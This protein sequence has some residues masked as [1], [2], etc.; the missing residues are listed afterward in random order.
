MN[1]VI[2]IA[3]AGVNHNGSIDLAKKLID[4]A[5]SAGADFVKFQTFKASRVVTKLGEKADYQVKN[6][7]SSDSQ[8]NMLKKLEL[9]ENDH[10]EL[11]SHCNKVGILFLSTPFDDISADFL[12]DKVKVFKIPSGEL[13]NKPFLVHIAHKRRPIILSTGMATLDEVL[14]SIS[15][16]KKIWEEIGAPTS[17]SI[18]EKELPPLSVLH[19]TTAYPA[20]IDSV[21]L[22]AMLTM[23][24]KLNIP[25]GYSDHTLGNTIPVAAVALGASIIEKHFTLDKEMDGPDHSM[26]MDPEELKSLIKEI[27]S[28]EL[29]LGSSS[30]EP[31]AIELKNIPSIRKSPYYSKALKKDST[32]TIEDIIMKRPYVRIDP[33]QIDN[34][35]GK[36]LL[37]DVCE[38]DLVE[39]E[40]IT[41]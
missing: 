41:N 30:K 38:E 18:N 23:E 36:R 19:C 2:V 25:V 5:K 6:T 37:R 4:S 12:E 40:D 32:I 29:A 8:Y 28:V 7:K 34:I 31:S 13:T 15:L 17:V 14:R 21:N 11:I 3:E 33:F 24:N 26:S 39:I 16:I 9:S 1:K 10:F 22:L 27:H 20:P 35:I